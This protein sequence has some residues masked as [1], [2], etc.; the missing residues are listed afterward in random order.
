M[1]FSPAPSLT[2]SVCL[3]LYIVST[4]LS[5][6]SAPAYADTKITLLDPYLP[7]DDTACPS[8]NP[9]SQNQNQIQLQNPHAASIDSSRIIRPDYASTPYAKLAAQAQQAWRS[10]YGGGEGVY[11]ES[12]I[13]LSAE[14]G[15]SAYVE[16]AYRN[17]RGLGYRVQGLRDKEEVGRALGT[18]G[19]G[20]ESGY[21]NFGGGWADAGRAMGCALGMV[22]EGGGG[23]GKG[24]EGGAEGEGEGG[25]EGGEGGEVDFYEWWWG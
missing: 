17:A 8:L 15:G 24:G 19:E 3:S 25:V 2:P 4:T 23:G 13:I 9:A 6:L 21:V 14:K 10:G 5:L 7:E 11:R 16:C 20:G 12:G 22:V 1:L 18:G